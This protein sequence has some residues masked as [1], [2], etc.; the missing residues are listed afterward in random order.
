MSCNSQQLARSNALFLKILPYISMF[1]FS[2]CVDAAGEHD[3]SLGKKKGNRTSSEK[4]SVTTL[5]MFMLKKSNSCKHCLENSLP[6]Q[7]TST[8]NP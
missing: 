8:S 5:C 4:V 1:F 2:D 3:H 6:N 7:H